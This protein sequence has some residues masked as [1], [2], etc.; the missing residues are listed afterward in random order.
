MRFAK[1]SSG[2]ELNLGQ[3]PVIFVVHSMGGLVVKKAYLL[4]MHDENY[5][6]IV[7]SI[8]AI[9]FLS[10]PHRGARLSETL[11]RVLSASFQ[12][13]KGF[14]TDLNKSSAAIEELNEQFRHLA[15]RLS[16][17]SFYETLA[18]SIGP[19]KVMVLEKES[20]VLGYPSELSRPLQADHHDMCKYSSPTD[21]SYISVKNTIKS[22]VALLQSAGEEKTSSNRVAD[23]A[24]VHELFRN[25]LTS[26]NEYNALRQFKVI[27][28]SRST[29][30]LS[31]AFDQLSRSTPVDHIDMTTASHTQQD[32]EC[33]I[34][35]EMEHMRGTQAFREWLK[36]NV[37]R[38]AQGNFLWAR[39]VSEELRDCHT[40]E[41][42][43]EVLD[44]IPDDM[45][46]F[47][48][49]MEATL[50][51][52]TRRS[53]QPLLKAL[54][55][56]STCAQR[57]LT[58][59]ELSR[60]LQPEFSGFIDLRR[61]IKDT[62]GQIVQVDEND[63][64]RILHHTAREYFTKSTTSQLHI[65]DCET[66]RR[67][68]EKSLAAL[69][70]PMLHGKLMESQRALQKSEPFAFYAA[71]NWSFHLAQSQNTTS[72]VLG[73]LVKFFQSSAVLAWI[74][75]LA[76]LQRLNVLRKVAKI[77]AIFVRTKRKQDRQL[78]PMYHR[79]LDLETIEDWI[80]DLIKVVGKF[81]RIL[82]AEPTVIYRIIPALCP[83]RSAL[84]RQ[85][86]DV[87]R[88][89]MTIWGAKDATWNDDLGR[90]ALPGDAQA[91]QIACA[92]KHLAV[93]ASTGVI[94]VWDSLSLVGLVTIAHGEA[95]TR[96]SL[97]GGGTKLATYGL[98]S[99]KVW[100]LPSGR[101]LSA[102]QNPRNTKAMSLVF[103]DNDKGLLVG[104]DD[105]S[106]RQIEFATFDQGWKDVKSN[107]LQETTRDGAVM[108]SPK[109]LAF[110]GD[111][112]LVGVSY[113]GAP[114]SVWRLSDGRC[115]NRCRRATDVGSDQRRPSA[116]WFGVDRF[117]WN[118][119]TDHILGIY[120][121]GCIFKWHPITNENVEARWSADEIAASPDGKLFA[122]SSSNGIVRIWSFT[123]FS[124]IYQLA[125][126]DLVTDLCFS[127][128]SRRF[129][130]LRGGTINAWESNSIT[131]FFENEELISDARSE[132][133]SS[134]AASRYAEEHVAEVDALTAFA[135]APHELSYCVGNED[136]LVELFANGSA[137][138]VEIARFYNFLHITDVTWSSKN[139]L[140][141]VADL[142]GEIKVLSTVLRSL[143]PPDDVS[144]QDIPALQIDLEGHSVEAL[145]FGMDDRSIF[146]STSMK[147]F[148]CTL[149]TGDLKATVA[150]REDSPRMW[151]HHPTQQDL[152]LAFGADD[153]Q[154][155]NWSDLRLV[156]SSNYSEMSHERRGSRF[157]SH[158]DS[159]SEA[160]EISSS[161]QTSD[162]T[163][164]LTRTIKKAF[165]T[166]DKK[167]VIAE[168]VK[169]KSLT[170]YRLS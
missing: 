127:P 14:I 76:I 154:A 130:D 146:V 131:R 33:Y 101:E 97:N 108:N 139:D 6:H 132:D 129:Y 95:V 31:R 142:A 66:H 140:V 145:V 151:L 47:Y 102:T 64:I 148:V 30:V 111:N 43:R 159:L 60:A 104:G 165:Q 27:V 62:C 4:G 89:A 81:G 9:I 152:L 110:N 158:M 49:R 77:L 161:P 40:E 100:S 157:D 125:S 167:H 70:D 113:R 121:D 32:I 106:V 112:T 155:Y 168:D 98:Q 74:H 8:S 156:Y 124:V 22:F 53:N 5:K 46:H 12:A 136:G 36:S 56:W 2:E 123:Y 3:N 7:Q 39:L 28:V 24:T 138:G 83:Q 25:C 17:C 122:T 147:A 75:A 61:T 42:T 72:K 103:S 11:N 84:K 94:Y 48:A 79:L 105:N 116:N 150:L 164:R 20:S 44:E 109:W 90:L 10:T 65:D 135:L 143:S 78:N 13:P 169:A 115:I 92:G 96:I 38:R 87:N 160:S 69:E 93:L 137:K 54:L 85:F 18:T 71:V 1:G 29:E 153:V 50:L 51:G 82:V 34:E 119:V 99:T 16:I 41:R 73:L 88:S 59:L 118:P 107:L 163:S 144:R 58:L 133:Q 26:E 19:K 80:T 21:P 86:Y 15:P 114:L 149:A 35:R 23:T 162:T 91:W 55:E 141:A 128:D 166:Q 45:N 170:L 120:R 134:T 67:L 68:F 37:I 57:P 52:T 117:T 126:D 63:K